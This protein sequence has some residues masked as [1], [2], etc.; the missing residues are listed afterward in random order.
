M[1]YERRKPH[2]YHFFFHVS[3]IEFVASPLESDRLMNAPILVMLG[4]Y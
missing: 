4:N 1:A 2:S 3:L